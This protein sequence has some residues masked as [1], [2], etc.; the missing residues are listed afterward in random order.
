VSLIPKFFTLNASDGAMGA[1]FASKLQKQGRKTFPP[2]FQSLKQY[3]V[4]RELARMSR[5]H[6]GI[7]TDCTPEHKFEMERQGK[8]DYPQVVFKVNKEGDLDGYLPAQLKKELR[9]AST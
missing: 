2:C 4:W 8:C 7:C 6:S 3:E 5:P 9:N 1:G